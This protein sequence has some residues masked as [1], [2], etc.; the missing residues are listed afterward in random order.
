V[1]PLRE[2]ARTV[3]RAVLAL[4]DDQLALVV[5]GVA[6]FADACFAL[7]G[8][9]FYRPVALVVPEPIAKGFGAGLRPGATVATKRKKKRRGAGKA[10]AK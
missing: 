7:L 6:T 1:T 3:A 5:R 2:A 9:S 10:G 8:P 4:P